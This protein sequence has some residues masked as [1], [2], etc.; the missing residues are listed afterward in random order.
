[1]PVHNPAKVPAFKPEAVL[2][3]AAPVQNTWYTVLDA[4]NV[5]IYA[6]AYLIA[7]TDETIE[8]RLT[9]DGVQMTSTQAPAT[10]DTNVWVGFGA[11]ALYTGILNPSISEVWLKL[12]AQ[13]CKVEIRKTSN[14]GV[15][16]LKCK[17]TYGAFG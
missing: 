2:D 1:M 8:T 3:Q 16:N 10:H 6:I 14:T 15:G 4:K 12:H 5:E 7:T 11:G 17:V 9:L 13:V